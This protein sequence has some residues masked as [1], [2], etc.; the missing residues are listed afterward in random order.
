MSFNWKG[1]AAASRRNPSRRVVAVS[2]EPVKVSKATRVC[3]VWDP[4]EM[5]SL[6][7]LKAATA[8]ATGPATRRKDLARPEMPLAAGGVAVARF[9][10][11]RATVL[12][13]RAA[14][15]A[16]WGIW[17]R[18][19]NPEEPR[20]LK[21]AVVSRAVVLR[22]PR[23]ARA[24]SAMSEKGM[25]ALAKLEMERPAVAFTS[26]RS[27]PPEARAENPREAALVRGPVR[28]A[29]KR[30]TPVVMGPIPALA[31]R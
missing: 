17:R 22:R 30:A 4:M 19:M 1:V 27:R 6:R 31:R 5:A 28:K 3:S 25:R 8:T 29:A 16:F 10:E 9:W 18:P 15:L 23:R 21:A 13:P 24:R 14:L 12:R 7:V 26:A 2:T 11:E 20:A